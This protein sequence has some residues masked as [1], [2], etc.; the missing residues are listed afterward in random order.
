METLLAC[1]LLA[2]GVAPTRDVRAPIA[3]TRTR[4]TVVD[5]RV[6]GA[7]PFRLVLDTGSP[8]TLVSGRAALAAGLQTKE[9][10]ARP[11]LMGIRGFRR[12]REI[13][14]GEAS[15]PDVTVVVMDHPIVE[16]L[17]SVDGPIDGIL[18]YSWFG[19]FRMVLDYSGATIT[20]TPTNH[21]P[22][23]ALTTMVVRVGGA[24]SRRVLVAPAGLWGLA[25]GP[26][27]DA[28]GLPVR[29]VARGSA[30]AAAGLRPGDRLLS[31]DGRWTDSA[32]DCAA[33]AMEHRPGRAVPVR[34]RR[35]G[36]E[37]ELRVVPRHGL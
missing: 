29:A 4:H 33:A 24:I 35:G 16:L 20:L 23:D 31:I 8:I 22:E 21:R 25:L 12:A 11:T 26:A 34:I 37:L 15:V 1:T 19:R 9:Q 3:V 14:V 27:D 5:A 18:G 28:G 32:L 13:A 2:T 6:N 10:A 36:T 7:G 17:S 30:A